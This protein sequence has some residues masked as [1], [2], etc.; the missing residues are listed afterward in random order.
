M[1]VN[2][3]SMMEKSVNSIKKILWDLPVSRREAEIKRI[4]KNPAK[5]IKKHPHLFV[6]ALNS[7]SWYELIDLFGTET[8]DEMLSDQNLDRI[9]P[10]QR[11]EYYKHARRLLSTYTLSASE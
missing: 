10:N 2:N 8:L 4:Q 1:M 9:F 3:G 5:Y 7:L 6:K 11:R